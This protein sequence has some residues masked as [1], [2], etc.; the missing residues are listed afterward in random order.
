MRRSDLTAC[1]VGV[2]CTHPGA[3]K[4][5]AEPFRFGVCIKDLAA[6]YSRGIYKTTTIG[7]AAFDVRVR[8]GNGSVH[9]FKATKKMSKEPDV[10]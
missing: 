8:N 3:P 9:C 1:E 6:T 5:N 10:L 2:A 4:Q 7:N